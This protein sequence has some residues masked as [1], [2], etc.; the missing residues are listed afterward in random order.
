MNKKTAVTKVLLSLRDGYS[1]KEAR[2]FKEDIKTGKKTQTGSGI[3][4]Y[5]GRTR[6]GE[7]F[8]NRADALIHFHEEVAK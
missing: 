1:I 8:K 2:E 5:S 7:R 3:Y 4:I 6:Q